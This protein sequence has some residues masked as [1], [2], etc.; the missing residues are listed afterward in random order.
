MGVDNY[1]QHCN[2]VL[3][4][5]KHL[6]VKAFDVGHATNGRYTP[7]F[8]VCASEIKLGQ[9]NHLVTPLTHIISKWVVLHAG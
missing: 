4:L 7:I 8:I 3:Q 6:L 9:P 2:P 1:N 5:I